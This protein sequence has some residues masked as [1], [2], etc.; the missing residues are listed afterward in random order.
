M[1]DQ[2][3]SEL[4]VLTDSE[5]CWLMQEVSRATATLHLL[6]GSLTEEESKRIRANVV[7][8]GLATLRRGRE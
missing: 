2:R 7:K 1:T 3:D 8:R 5:L 6:L 4:T